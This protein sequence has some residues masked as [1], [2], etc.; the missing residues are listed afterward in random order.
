MGPASPPPA[1]MRIVCW[2]SWAAAPEARRHRAA[3]TSVD[4]IMGAIVDEVGPIRLNTREFL[5]TLQLR[6]FRLKAETTDSCRKFRLK[7]ETT[8]TCRKFRLKAEATGT[9]RSFRLKAEA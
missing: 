2:I 5:Q 9:C 1:P 4:R 8:D 6:R 3:P 7:A